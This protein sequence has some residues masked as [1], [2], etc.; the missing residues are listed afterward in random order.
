MYI[1]LQNPLLSDSIRRF[2]AKT[3]SH[4]LQAI[5]YVKHVQVFEV[6]ICQCYLITKNFS[7]VFRMSFIRISFQILSE[8]IYGKIAKN[9][10]LPTWK[11]STIIYLFSKCYVQLFRPSCKFLKPLWYARS[12]CFVTKHSYLLPLK[13]KYYS[14]WNYIEKKKLCWPVICTYLE[15]LTP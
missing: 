9:S 1:Y 12:K 13:Q 6:S 3:L 11:L 14:S 8:K 2:I 7:Y 5:T 4:H 10:C 15:N